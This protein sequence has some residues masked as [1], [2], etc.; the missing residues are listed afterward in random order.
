VKRTHGQAGTC[1]HHIAITSPSLNLEVDSYL[2]LDVKFLVFFLYYD[3]I[4][5]IFCY[6]EHKFD[7][8]LMFRIDEK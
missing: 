8:S 4:T 2:Y 6:C 5:Y 1:M 3:E 7:L